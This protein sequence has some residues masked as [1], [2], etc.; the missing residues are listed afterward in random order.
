MVW[1]LRQGSGQGPQP[2]T[3]LV[4]PP[5][6][7]LFRPLLSRASG[8]GPVRLLPLSFFRGVLAWGLRGPWFP[9]R[10]ASSQRHPSPR[11][12]HGQGPQALS[13]MRGLQAGLG[14]TEL[15][16]PSP[17]LSSLSSQGGCSGNMPGA[18]RDGRDRGPAPSSF[19]RSSSQ[20]GTLLPCPSEAG[21]PSQPRLR[22]EGGWDPSRSGVWGWPALAHL[23]PSSGES[24]EARTCAPPLPDQ[25]AKPWERRARLCSQTGAAQQ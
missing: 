3:R 21:G 7:L 2:P 9:L 13:T 24:Q 22:S 14:H 12:R 6:S 23:E 11:C 16:T 19:L 18:W 10:C 20:P 25:G 8:S 15:L 1:V 17:P 5:L 4:P